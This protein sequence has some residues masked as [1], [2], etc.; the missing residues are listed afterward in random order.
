MGWAINSLGS[1]QDNVGLPD[2]GVADDGK[3]VIVDEG[4]WTLGEAGGGGGGGAG[5]LLITAEW[6]DVSQYVKGF[7]SDIDAD[8]IVAAYTSGANC[9]IHVVPSEHYTEFTRDL[10]Q[11]IV[12]YAPEEDYGGGDVADEVVELSQTQS[13]ES[14]Y[15]RVS[16]TED[17]KFLFQV[18]ID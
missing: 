11:S 5:G 12:G 3:T 9:V 1:A 13:M 4:K 14:W 2:V 15:T 16:R 8:D 17:G 10:Y 18:Y 7:K 6:A